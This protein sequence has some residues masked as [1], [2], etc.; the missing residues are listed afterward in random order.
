MFTFEVLQKLDILGTEMLSVSQL[1][2]TLVTQN[3]LAALYFTHFCP[4]FMVFFLKF[5]KVESIH[6]HFI[7]L[8]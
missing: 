3:K 1:N 5:L 4:N 2:V 8:Y 6:C 7:Y